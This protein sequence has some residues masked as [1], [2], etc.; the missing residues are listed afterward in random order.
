MPEP[1]TPR[2]FHESEG[3]EDWRVL[4]DGACARYRT[5]SLVEGARLVVAIAAIPGLRPRQPDIDLRHDSVTVRLITIDGDYYGMTRRDAELA[6]RISSLARG[7]GLTA[8]VDGLHSVLIIPGAPDIAAVMPFWK[9]ALGY[10]PRPDSPSEDLVDPDGRMPGF[11][12]EPMDEPRPGGLAA[13]HVAVFVPHEHGEARVA[14]VLAAG[15]RIVRDEF[16]PAWV[17]LADAAGNEVDI[18]ATHTRE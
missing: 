4:A 18:A 6:R 9:A 15:G 8:H 16:A 3:T 12:F 2:Q 1:I 7:L 17:T 14:A 13:I 5:S 11:W 10:V